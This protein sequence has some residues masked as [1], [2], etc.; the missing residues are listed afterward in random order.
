MSA[1]ATS[2]V[3]VAAER[4]GAKYDARR[5]FS[6]VSFELHAG[7]SLAV[8]G[9]NGSGKSTL[10]R[11]IA[12][13]LRPS[14]GAVLVN[15]PDPRLGIGYAALDQ[16][17]YPYLTVR[18]HLDFAARLRGCEPRAEE[19]LSMVGL[20]KATSRAASA[21]SSGMRARLR[22]ALAIQPAPAILVLDEPGAGL[23]EEGHALVALVISEQRERGAVVLATNDELER[24][25]A[26]AELRLVL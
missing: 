5:V 21:L 17:L 19:L 24:R 3:L 11:L 1:P 26:N 16:S 6:G 15:H 10:L 12:G 14:E 22:L 4:L 13:L 20:E 8:L 9:P 7:D 23:D 18:E 2:P 25:H